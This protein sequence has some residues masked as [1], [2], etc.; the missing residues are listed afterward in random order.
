[1][2]TTHPIWRTPAVCDAVTAGD[3]GTLIRMGR[4]AR[5]LTL[6]QAGALCGYSASTLSRI[7]TGRQPLTDVTLLRH[8]AEAFGIPPQF[9]GLA[10]APDESSPTGAATA[11][12]RASVATV[13]GSAARKDGDDPVRRRRVL[14]GLVG[15]TGATLLGT[16]DQ[17]AVQPVSAQALR[18]SLAAARS[19]FQHCHYSDLAT[20]LPDLITAAQ[21]SRDVAT[22]HQHEALSAL[23]ADAYSLASNLCTRLYDDALAW[24]T[25]D[26]ARSAAQASGNV[27]S[28]AE[29]ARVASIA[30]RRHGHHDTAISL[31]TS[32]ALSLGADTG[33]PHPDLLGTYGS[34]LCTASYTA[35]QHGHRSHALELIGEADDAARRVGRPT[36]IHAVFST[37]NVAIYQIGVRNALGDA[38]AALDYARRIEIR[39]LPSPE[40]QARFCL[41][42]ARAWHRFGDSRKCYQALQAAEHLAPE[43]LRRPSVRSLV[44]ILLHAPGPAPSGLR[45]FAARIG[46]PV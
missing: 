23:L 35:A 3:F 18:S 22:G 6:V 2:E 43:E 34:L 11:P 1:M 14:T 29:A 45:G 21:A 17:A 41:D 39:C 44:A 19:L 42:T 38:G 27:A 30:M 37:T 16:T 12:P 13:R 33:S 26:R 20:A 5:N 7:E 8:F 46:V 15:V 9:F 10:P 25:A 36:T 24:V 31:L 4:T 40:R 28:L 32:T